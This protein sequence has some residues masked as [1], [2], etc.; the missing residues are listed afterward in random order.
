MIKRHLQAV[1]KDSARM[2]PVITLTGPRQSGKTTLARA[3]FTK[4]HY[5]SLEDPA[6]R[7]LALDDSKGFLSQFG[8]EQV[9]LDE[10]QRAPDLFSYIQVVVDENDIP[11]QYI[12][13]G[14]QNFLLMEKISQ[15][16]AGRCAIHHLLPFSRLELIGAKPIDPENITSLPRLHRKKQ[17][18]PELFN[19]LWTGGYPRIHDK[20]IPPQQWLANYIQTYIERDVRSIENVSDLETFTRFVRL[21]AG[22][23]GQILNLQSLGNDCGIDGKTTKRWLSILETSF[24]IKLLRPYNKNF[25]KRLIKSPKLYF[26]D[27][28]LLCYLLGIRKPDELMVH[29]SRGAIFE[30]WVISELY[31]SYYH[32]GRQPAMYY[33]RDSNNNE[34]DLV[35]EHGPK[36]VPIEI[37]SG[38]TINSEFFK[39]LEYWRRVT[40]QA[41][42]PAALIYGGDTP[43]VYKNIKIIP[44]YML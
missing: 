27:S 2:F 25:S 5:V 1:L 41:D 9:I 13:T 38:Q 10:A 43:N 39:G 40:G 18:I 17:T 37:K 35:I 33:L 42:C 29:S 36:I 21:C 23:T 22:R 7:T 15:S 24:V 19:I 28:G 26:L 12:L 3:T 44:W 31:K 4:A 14:S 6:Q 20:H 11:G 32:T 8:T 30:S 34:I 16:L